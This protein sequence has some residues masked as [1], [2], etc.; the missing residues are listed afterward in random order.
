MT[1]TRA[2]RML[3]QASPP[4]VAQLRNSSDL[5][6]DVLE[7][8]SIF[9]IRH[10]DILVN[11]VLGSGL[12]G[13]LANL[14]LRRR[15]RAGIESRP[16]LGPQAVG[17][18]R[19]SDGGVTWEGFFDG[20]DHVCTLRLAATDATW[21]WTVAVSNTTAHRLTI[22]VVLAQDLGIAQAAAVRTSELYTSQYIDH[23][24]VD[25]AA[26]GLLLCSRQGLPQ[27]GAFPWVMHGCL[28]GAVGYLTDGFQFHGLASKASGTPSALARSALPNQTYQYELALPTLQS[29]AVSMAAGASA[30]ITFFGAFEPDHPAAS[31]SSDV[32]HA[33]AAG[34]A[35]RG[36]SSRS[37]EPP[38]QPQPRSSSLFDRPVLFQSDDLATAELEAA[39]G[40]GWR[41]VERANETLYS[42][43]HGDQQHVVLRAKE[44][45]QE[46][47]TGHLL[48]SGRDLLPS[49]AT[50]A[51]TAWMFGVFASQ[52]TIGNTSF[53]KLLSVC[54]SPLNVLKSSGLRI[55]I[56]TDRGDELLGVPSAF[57]M[58]PSGAAWLYRDR[59]LRMMIRLAVSVEE[60][61]CRLTV[62]VEVGGPI[63]LIVCHNIVL[64]EHEFDPVG[65]IVIHEADGRIELRPDATSLL[66]RRYP[67]ASFTITTDP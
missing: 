4:I 40:S 5:A 16:L 33:H 56:R 63:E 14:F 47:P 28:A 45:V 13:G 38:P 65:P 2:T 21:F 50:L 22:D 32:R 20:L 17:R 27:D 61:V 24:I 62:D 23:T 64:G 12:E 31:D 57:E 37:I 3:G 35:F 58:G 55:F 52:L 26:L 51:V 7:N 11:Q 53:H 19:A 39:F 54:R 34:R 48:R 46:R 44:L 49:D 59:R 1:S 15:S 25:D 67:E 42:F 8:G 66:G 41:H 9:A 30:E 43:F 6:V 29:R 18:F 60:P 10:R 36:L